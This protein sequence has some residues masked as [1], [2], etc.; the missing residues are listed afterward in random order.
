MIS[1]EAIVIL[2]AIYFLDEKKQEALNMAIEALENNDKLAEDLQKCLEMYKKKKAEVKALKRKHGKWVIE[3]DGC[4]SDS[5]YTAYCSNCRHY[6]NWFED[7]YGSSIIR[8][9]PN[10]CSNCGADMR[11]IL[12]KP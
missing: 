4:Y 1:E 9:L 11:K 2:K 5:L 8:D 7:N 12:P 3:E 6:V 10:Y